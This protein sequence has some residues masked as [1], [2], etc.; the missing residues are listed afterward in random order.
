MGSPS[1]SNALPLCAVSIPARPFHARLRGHSRGGCCA[2]RSADDVVVTARKGCGAFHHGKSRGF[3]HLSSV[4]ADRATVAHRAAACRQSLRGALERKGMYRRGSVVGLIVAAR[5]LCCGPMQAGFTRPPAPLTARSPQP[6]LYLTSLNLAGCIPGW[7]RTRLHC[8]E[9][10]QDPKSGGNP[11]DGAA[12]RRAVSDRG[13]SSAQANAR[14]AAQLRQ[15][16]HRCR[17]KRGGQQHCLGGLAGW[18][19]LIRETPSSFQQRPGSGAARTPAQQTC[20]VLLVQPQ[21]GAPIQLASPSPR[22]VAG[23]ALGGAPTARSTTTATARGG[24][25]CGGLARGCAH[26]FPPSRRA[27]S[28]ERGAA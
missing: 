19:R 8:S 28:F 6:V 17:R 18:L 15:G 12:G 14:A 11:G 1:N 22:A 26:I 9:F 5:G 3:Y 21:A 10:Q 13:I 25:D 2:P 24:N 20:C 23:R 4:R 7:R 27:S 16:W